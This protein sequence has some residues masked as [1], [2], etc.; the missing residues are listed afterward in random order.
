L[1]VVRLILLTV[2]VLFVVGYVGFH[3]G[4]VGQSWDAASHTVEA[5]FDDLKRL[6]LRAIHHR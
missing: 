6:A 3:N 2:L 1:L 4:S 5:G